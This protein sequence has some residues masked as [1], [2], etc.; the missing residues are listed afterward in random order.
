[1]SSEL[2]PANSWDE[3]PHG[4]Q[5]PEHYWTRN[6]ESMLPDEIVFPREDHLIID[7][8]TN[9]M[10]VEVNRKFDGDISQ[11][12]GS[13]YRQPFGLLRVYGENTAGE[14][15]DGYIADIRTIKDKHISHRRIDEDS[16]G[17][18]FRGSRFSTLEFGKYL[19]LLGVIHNDEKGNMQYGS[20]R[21]EATKD[22]ALRLAAVMDSILAKII[23]AKDDSYHLKISV[24]ETA[25]G[26]RLQHIQQEVENLFRATSPVEIEKPQTSKAETAGQEAEFDPAASEVQPSTDSDEPGKPQPSWLK[27]FQYK[28]L[29]RKPQD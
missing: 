6:P 13:T 26:Q 16:I 7:D 3:F 9:S 20:P 14:F 25:A 19:P 12:E 1:M 21:R 17:D 8:N 29:T 2:P 28:Y 15:I 27:R 18:N 4:P 22:S 10:L 23:E 11:W 5:V 24:E